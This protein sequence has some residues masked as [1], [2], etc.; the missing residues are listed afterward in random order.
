MHPRNPMAP[1]MHFNYRYFETEGGTWWFGGGSDLTPS[2]LFE[3][4]VKHFHQTYKVIGRQKRVISSQTARGRH[5]ISMQSARTQ[6]PI[7]AP[8]DVCDKHDPEYYGRF[9][10]WADEYFLI[11]HRGETRGVGGIFFDG[12]CDPAEIA[13]RSLGDGSADLG[14]LTQI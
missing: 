4:D 8:Q 14:L 5:A 13:P 7:S 11:K 9:K 3:E 1:T 10:K 6:R 12:A 2:Y